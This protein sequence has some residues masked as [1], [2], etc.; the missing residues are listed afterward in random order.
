MTFVDLKDLKNMNEIYDIAESFDKEYFEDG[1]RTG[2]S[3]YEKYRWLPEIAFS[4]AC[5]IKRL[6]PN[7]RILDYGA[8]KGYIVYALRLMG[9]DAYGYDISKYAIKNCK[10]E[11]KNYMYINKYGIP[12]ID[13]VFGKDTLEHIPYELIKDELG[14][15][16]DK[17][18]RACFL[19]PFGE[20][21]RYRIGEYSYDRTHIICENEEWWT[22][23]FR[24]AGFI[25]AD[26]T[27]Y[28][29]GFKDNWISHHP[30]GNGVFF[31]E[32]I[33]E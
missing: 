28:F 23:L 21:G 13:I 7:M 1:I 8:A 31:L 27:H 15:I 12:D 4:R 5:I 2:K 33:E 11:I 25:I 32:K 6:Y 30:Y 22:L 16:F 24:Q 9:V 29:P 20:N 10:P 17:C 3:L 14:W 19:V 18:S 26:F